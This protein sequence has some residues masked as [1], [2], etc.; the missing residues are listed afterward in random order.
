MGRISGM[1]FRSL[2]KVGLL[3][4]DGVGHGAE[5]GV[6]S[7]VLEDVDALRGLGAELGEVRLHPLDP[8]VHLDVGQS[9]VADASVRLRLPLRQH[10]QALSEQQP[11]STL[12]RA[13]VPAIGT[14]FNLFRMSFLI[15]KPSLGYTFFPK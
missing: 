3:E 5:G 14:Q 7:V 9:R 15:C 4:V 1:L 8:L 6:E 11:Q 12:S 13:P 10:R 2:K